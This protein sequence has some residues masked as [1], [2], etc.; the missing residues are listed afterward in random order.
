MK[1]SFCV[2]SKLFSSGKIV[3]VVFIKYGFYPYSK[4]EKRKEGD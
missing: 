3:I 4:F 2:I 1:T